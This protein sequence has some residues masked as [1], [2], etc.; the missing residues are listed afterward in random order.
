MTASSWRQELALNI[1]WID[2]Q[3]KRFLQ[4]LA[5]VEGLIAKGVV[6]KD[7]WEHIVELGNYAKIHFAEEEKNMQKIGYAEYEGHKKAHAYF[8]DHVFKLMEAYNLADIPSPNMLSL[9]VFLRTWFEKHIAATDRCYVQGFLDAGLEKK[10][11]PE[12]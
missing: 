11:P 1:L 7:V 10:A 9:A 2:C 3:H 6:K 8:M 5:Q 4:M 12:E